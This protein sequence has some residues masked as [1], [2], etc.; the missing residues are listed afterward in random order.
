[1]APATPPSRP[2]AWLKCLSALV[3]AVVCGGLLALAA[4]TPAPPGVLVAVIVICI[5]CPMAAAYQLPGAVRALRAQV[6][7]ARWRRRLDELPEA[8][9]PLGF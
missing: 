2:R 1:M 9:H 8:P 4:L 3:T 5:V 6:D 7:A